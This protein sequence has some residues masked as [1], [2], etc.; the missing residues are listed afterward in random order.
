MKRIT[1]FFAILAVGTSSSIPW[2]ERNSCHG[3]NT[4]EVIGCTWSRHGTK[5]VN[6][7]P[8]V[9]IISDLI[10]GYV[11][12][13]DAS[14]FLQ[15]NADHVGLHAAH[16]RQE[17]R[18]ILNLMLVLLSHETSTKTHATTTCGLGGNET[19]RSRRDLLNVFNSAFGAISGFGNLLADI[20]TTLK[21]LA[22][23]NLS[24]LRHDALND[25]YVPRTSSS[26]NFLDDVADITQTASILLRKAGV[27]EP[28]LIAAIPKVVQ[29]LA[30]V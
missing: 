13:E 9:N 3:E 8:V 6:M 24:P 2:T 22:K 30:H 15:W 29:S 23:G 4:L 11:S 1:I 14:D 26:R 7:A 20:P 27:P 12:L 17:Y 21:G 16:S 5:F 18:N 28:Q 25:G 19:R 10:N